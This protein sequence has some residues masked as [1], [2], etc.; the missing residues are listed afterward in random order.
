[1]LTQ[2]EIQYGYWR[3]HGWPA[4]F[5]KPISEVEEYKGQEIL[6]I[7]YAKE[8]D[9]ASQRK[10]RL[11]Q[12]CDLLPG[13]NIRM[14]FFHAIHQD[15]FDAAMQIKEL[16]A[17]N[18][19]YGRLKTMEAV[20]NCKSLK[21][22]IIPSCPSLTGLAFLEKLPNL[23]MLDIENVREAQ[24][25]SFVSSMTTLEDFGIN[26]SLWTNQKVNDLWPLAGLQNLQVL[27]LYSTR[28]LKDGLLPLHHLKKL[29]KLNCS[30]HYSTGEFKALRDALPSLQYGTPIDFPEKLSGEE[31][32]KRL[33]G[34]AA[35]KKP[36]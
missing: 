32:F 11:K 10:R 29:V 30:L 9:T 12:W 3:A 2:E 19:G 28:V 27:R 21:S 1:M 33:T 24:D 26:G 16:E 13:L 6:S 18:T 8:L 31:L 23:K 36:G 25:L 4:S 17:V 35:P 7:A 20:V 15:L 14:L 22:I 5:L 34:S